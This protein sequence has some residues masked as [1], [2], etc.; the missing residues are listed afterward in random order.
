VGNASIAAAEWASLALGSPESNRPPGALRQ[1][2]PTTPARAFAGLRRGTSQPRAASETEYPWIG[3][4]L[5]QPWGD[6]GCRGRDGH[7]RRGGLPQ[8]I[9]LCRGEGVGLVG[10][11]AEGP[12]QGQGFGGEGAGGP[13]S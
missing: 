5:R 1:L 11:V 2:R 13:K 8:E 6:S 3:W 9:I 4:W 12:L 10:E 7:A